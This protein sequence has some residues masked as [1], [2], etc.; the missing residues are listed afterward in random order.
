M[1]RIRD[2]ATNIRKIETY[3]DFELVKKKFGPIYEEL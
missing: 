3:F 2:V 1:L